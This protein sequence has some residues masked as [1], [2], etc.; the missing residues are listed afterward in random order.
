MA[1]S[2][3]PDNVVDVSWTDPSTPDEV[4]SLLVAWSQSM[5]TFSGSYDLEQE[6][7]ADPDTE[8]WRITYRWDGRNV[9]FQQ[10]W[11]V[12]EGVQTNAYYDG[13]LHYCSD[14]SDYSYAVVNDKKKENTEFFW[15]VYLTPEA[16]FGQYHELSLADVL[17]E[18]T[19]RFL[20]RDGDRIVSHTNRDLHRAVDIHLDD[21][22]R[23]KRLEW[24]RRPFS[25]SDEQLRTIWSGDPF[26]L[27]RKRFSLDLSEYAVIEGV[28]FP[29]AATK[30][31]WISNAEAGERLNQ[32][33]D[34]G[35]ISMDEL[36]IGLYT[37]EENVLNVQRLQFESVALNTVLGK[38]DFSLDC[39]ENAQVFDESKRQKDNAMEKI[40]LKRPSWPYV[41][42]V[43]ATLGVISFA[44]IVLTIRA[45]RRAKP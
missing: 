31:W 42:I 2:A 30:T 10:E 36:T 26:D 13:L 43:A 21:Q 35:E 3:A 29:M 16:I 1:G 7:T 18:G 39:P 28:P 38:E 44:G 5:Q 19:T 12:P 32:A 37:T 17:A 20:E 41:R 23:V 9:Y 11:F 14:S 33:Y 40:A 24:V 8:R 4:K 6:I 34:R 27:R 22:D 15:S 45:R 25:Y